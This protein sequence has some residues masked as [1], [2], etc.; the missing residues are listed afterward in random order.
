MIDLRPNLLLAADGG[1]GTADCKRRA[2]AA[3]I[4]VIEVTANVSR[5]PAGDAQSNSGNFYD[6]AR[7]K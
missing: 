7:L 3:G 1:K 5:Q 4:P 2:R 6:H